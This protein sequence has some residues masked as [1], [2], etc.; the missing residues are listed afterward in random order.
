MHCI[1]TTYSFS[2]APDK[3]PLE[4]ALLHFLFTV[5]RLDLCSAAGDSRFR[6]RGMEE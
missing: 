3:F 5:R 2:I 4:L 6:G 1:L